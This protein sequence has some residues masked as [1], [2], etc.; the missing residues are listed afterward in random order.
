[1][2]GAVSS[3]VWI[4][5]RGVKER[6]LRSLSSSSAAPPDRRLAA[7]TTA[8]E[9]SETYW[10]HPTKWWWSGHRPHLKSAEHELRGH[11]RTTSNSGQ[12]LAQITQTNQGKVGSCLWMAP[13]FG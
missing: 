2:A 1:R 9:G 8:R 7:E 11:P 10:D 6:R 4:A 5:S 12:H 13:N 3:R